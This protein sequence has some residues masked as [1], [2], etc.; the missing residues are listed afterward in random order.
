MA[1][2]S[3]KII[4]ST[5]QGG[6]TQRVQVVFTDHFSKK[7]QRQYDF[8]KDADINAEILIRQTHVEQGLKDQDIEKAVSKVSAG[9]SFSL[10]YA[11]DAELKLRLQEV[12]IEKQAEIDTLT[13][14]KANISATAGGL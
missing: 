9:K 5:I 12:E 1:I 6:G 14:E 10:E 2:T 7:H 11:T 8:P 13:D 3:N 4:E